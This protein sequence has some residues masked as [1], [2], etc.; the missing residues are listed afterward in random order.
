MAPVRLRGL[1][2]GFVTIFILPFA[3]YLVYCELLGHYATWR[4][5]FWIVV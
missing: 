2:L 1:Y 3:P 5:S 4:W